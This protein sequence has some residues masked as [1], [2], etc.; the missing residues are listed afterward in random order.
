MILLHNIFY[1]GVMLHMANKKYPNGL[2]SINRLSIIIR[3]AA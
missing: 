2:K 3:A 1:M